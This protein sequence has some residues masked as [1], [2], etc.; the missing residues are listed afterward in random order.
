MLIAADS[1]HIFTHTTPRQLLSDRFKLESFRS[2]S[3]PGHIS[4]L[5]IGLGG[6]SEF[7][8]AEFVPGLG[9]VA[10]SFHHIT[11]D[12]LDLMNG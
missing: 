9:S 12:R 10:R 1:T 2:D 5:L 6:L 11:L 7:Q 3:A 4:V 8:G